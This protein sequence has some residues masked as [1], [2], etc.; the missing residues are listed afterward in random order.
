MGYLFLSIIATTLVFLTFKLIGRYKV[1][2]FHAIVFNYVVC[3]GL[4]FAFL[5]TEAYG[6]LYDLPASFYQTGLA[7]GV[8]FVLNF[9]AMGKTTQVFGVAP[10]TITARMSLIIPALFSVWVFDE[11]FNFFKRIGIVTALAAVYLS[12]YEPGMGRKTKERDI[13]GLLYLFPVGAFLGTGII[14]SLFKVAQVSFLK[15]VPNV[16]F[17]LML[18]G[19]AGISGIFI[20][21]INV[22]FNRESFQWKTLLFGAVLGVVNFFAIYFLL[23]ALSVSEMEGSVL[24]PVNSVSIVALSTFASYM[25]FGERLNYFNKM[26]FVLAIAAILLITFA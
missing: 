8:L 25:V 5:P 14:D 18:F 3:V 2:T 16:A 20:I 12:L 6:K 26:G 19:I 4:G 10:A 7:I 24:F 1:H 11:T 21:I 9:W 23:L 13:S 22:I 15:D 17:L